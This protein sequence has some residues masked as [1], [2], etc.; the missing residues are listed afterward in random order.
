MRARVDH[1]YV[2]VGLHVDQDA[3]RAAVVLHIAGLA[4]EVDRPDARPASVEDRLDAAALV[5]HEDLP[6]D[7]VVGEPV[8]VLAR[9]R[10]AQH[11]AR[12][13][14]DRQQLVVVRR[15]R[16]DPPGLRDGDHAVHARRVDRPHHPAAPGVEGEELTGVHV[17][18]PEP[19]VRRVEAR[20]VEAVARAREGDV[21]DRPQRQVALRG[22][23]GRD[24]RG[25]GDEREHDHACSTNATP[26]PGANVHSW[27]VPRRRR[28]RSRLTSSGRC[29]PASGR[30]GSAASG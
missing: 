28:S 2:V 19:A 3:P 10:A 15:R 29:L 26:A 30:G 23:S 13:G 16:V 5:G 21:R 4:A 18:D 22:G 20:V 1:R 24:R 27:F 12:A 17:G 25:R 8:G 7:R 6:L 9:V 14:I 11:A